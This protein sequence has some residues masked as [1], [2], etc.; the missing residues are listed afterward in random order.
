MM[1]I[2]NIGLGWVS[3]VLAFLLS[4]IYILRVVNKYFFDNKHPFLTKWNKKLRKPHIALGKVVL[5]TALIHGLSSTVD[6]L[7]LNYGTYVFVV[8]VLLGVTFDLKKQLKPF[9]GFMFYHRILTLAMVILLVLHLL[10]VGIMGPS[11]FI[12]GAKLSLGLFDESTIG[13]MV[14]EP[15]EDSKVES[16]TETKEVAEEVIEEVI[17][18]NNGR[19]YSDGTYTGVATGF[20]E[21][22]TVEVV[23]KDNQIISVVIV[24][25]FEM[26]ENFWGIPVQLIPELIIEAQDPLVDSVSGASMTS[27]GI[28]NATI[29]ALEE[30]IIE[31]DLPELQELPKGRGNKNH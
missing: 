10:D 30:A 15:I 1:F 7:S 27:I 17:E 14:N 6:V 9:K 12:N 13:E 11:N 25:H 28:M 21:G 31:G 16:E 22:L 8:M 5:A 24:E 23:I 3:V 18:L 19:L 29:N 2:L 26:N 20:S 4:I